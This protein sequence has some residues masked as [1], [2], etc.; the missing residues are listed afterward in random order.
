MIDTDNDTDLTHFT[1]Y[2]DFYLSHRIVVSPMLPRMR[3]KGKSSKKMGLCCFADV[4]CQSAGGNMLT[5]AG[6]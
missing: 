6:V 2:N 5:T 3:E 1:E 4:C